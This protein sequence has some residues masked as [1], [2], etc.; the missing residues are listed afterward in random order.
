M[1]MLGVT[2]LGQKGNWLKLNVCKWRERDRRRP[3]G[4][5]TIIIYLGKST[6]MKYIL[7]LFKVFSH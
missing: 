7:I 6:S 5:V 2:C 4:R 1:S 3:R